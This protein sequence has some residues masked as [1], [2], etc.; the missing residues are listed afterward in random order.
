MLLLDSDVM[1]DIIRRHPPARD[2]ARAH[3]AEMMG[4]PGLV[5]MELL[6]GCRNQDEQRRPE[7]QLRSHVMY[8]PS[9]GDCER[10]YR[11]YAAFHLSHGLEI[12][13]ALIAETAVGL[14]AALATFNGKHYRAIAA[15]QVVEPYERGS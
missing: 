7:A 4:L 9:L 13:D 12:L 8:W 10:A 14:G 5:A 2:W 1:I 6:Q 15:L 11:D 3:A